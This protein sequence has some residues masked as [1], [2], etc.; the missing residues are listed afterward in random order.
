[1][2]ILGLRC[3]ELRIKDKDHTWR[4]IYRIDHDAIVIADV[5]DKDD[6]KTPKSVIEN[7]KRRYGAYD[8]AAKGES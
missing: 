5:F 8:K 1:M 2:P 6:N 7:T 3:H 4:I